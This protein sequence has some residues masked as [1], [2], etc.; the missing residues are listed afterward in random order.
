MHRGN[1]LPFS[2]KPSYT[3]YNNYSFVTGIIQGNHNDNVE[4]WAYGRYINCI[5]NPGFGFHIGKIADVWKAH[6]DYISIINRKFGVIPPQKLVPHM[7]K[8]LDEGY[9]IM[10]VL[11][12][13][14]IPGMA[15]YQKYRFMH[16]SLLIGFDD[17]KQVFLLYGRLEDRNMHLV[18]VSYDNIEKAISKGSWSFVLKYTPKQN[19]Q[20]DILQ[21]RTELSH[22]LYSAATGKKVQGTKYGVSAVEYL[23]EYFA[24]QLKNKKKLDYRYTRGLIEQKSLMLGM[25]NYLNSHDYNLSEDILTLC[26]EATDAAQKIHLFALKSHINAKSNHNLGKRIKKQFDILLDCER[27]YIPMLLKQLSE[28]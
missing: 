9:Y 24:K 11:D 21:I 25:C 7:K 28:N 13:Q 16:D 10:R 17:D 3:I 27:K 18:E 4:P 26:K 8:L 22:Y 6:R 23:S 15:A 20:L 2:V 19:E 14:Y 12:E 1:Q 5:F